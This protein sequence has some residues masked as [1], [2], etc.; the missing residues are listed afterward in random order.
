MN[1]T[2]I[3][4]FAIW[5]RNKLMDDMAYKAGLLG[6]SAD[7][8]AEPLPQSTAAMQ[9]IDIGTDTPYRV[10]GAAVRQ[11]QKF[12]DYIHQKEAD[13]DYAA[14]YQ[15][16]I[17]ETAYT[18]FN[19][20][21][22]VRFMEVNGYL[23]S[24]VRVLSSEQAG[25]AEPDMVTT[26]F[27]TDLEFTAEETQDI[28]R[29]KREN[30]INTL[31]RRLFIRQCNALNDILPHL[32]EKT[33]DYTELLLNISVTDHD[34][35]V[36]HLVHDIDEADFDI[37]RGGQVEIIG[38]LYQYYN[39]EPK[40]ETFAL[41]KKNIKVTK[42]RIPSA[43]QLFTPDWIVRYMVENSLGRLWTEGRTASNFDWKYYIPEAQQEPAVQE[44]LSHIRAEYKKLRPEDLTIIDP[45]MGSGHILI[46]AF[47][48]LMQIYT[49]QGYSE[50]DAAE[51]ILTHN[52]Y[53]LDIDERAFQ[54]A[55]FSVLMK[56][57][58]YDR[59]IL[60]KHVDIHLCAIPESNGLA[61][62]S[63]ISGKDVLGMEQLDLDNQY[64]EMADYL[65]D[66]FHDAKEYG[67]ILQVKE[68]DYDGL[69][70]YIDRMQ[71][72]G[73]NLIRSAWIREIA[74]RMPK[75]VQQAKIM[76]RQYWTCVTNPP[77]M[78]SSNMNSKLT[79]YVKKQYP[80]SKS[81][82]STVCMEM[83]LHMLR[84][85]GIM[86][87]I[88]IPVWMFL[89]SYE[90]LRNE[91]QQNDTYINMVHLGR[92]VFGSDFGTT[93][94]VIAKQRI[95][96]YSGTYRRL[97]MK[98]GAVDSVEQKEKWFLEGV[99]SYTAS[100]E[101]FSKIPGEP[102]AYWASEKFID[103]FKYVPLKKETMFKEGLT[104]ANNDLFLRYW[105]E[106]S[107]S[108][109]SIF[110]NT[111]KWI[112]YNKGGSFRKWYGNRLY[113]IDWTNE[114][115]KI[116]D[117]PGSSF[118]NSVYQRKEGG[119][120][121]A[122]TSGAFSVRYSEKGF[123]FDSKGTMFF[124]KEL[125]G[126]VICYLNSN[127][128]NKLLTFV[129]PTL[130]YRFGTIEKL[131][132]LKVDC[133]ASTFISL[134]R[135]DWDSFETSWDFPSHPLAVMAEEKR[136]LLPRD[137]RDTQTPAQQDRASR[138]A[139]RY[140]QWKKE[141]NHRFDTLQS[142][143]TELNR[144]FIDIYGLQDELTP[145]VADKDI[146]VHRLYDTKDDVPESM[147]GSN[148]ILTKQD[149]IKSLISYAVGCLFGR[150]S[151]DMP[152]LA[153]AGGDWDSSHYSTFLP[154]RDN[155]IPIAD[156]EYMKDDMTGLFCAWVKAVYGADTLEENLDFIAHA[157][158]ARGTT[159]RDVIRN[160]FL[161]DFYKDHVKT[162]KKRPIYW[163]FDSGRQ[164]GFK[165]LIYMHRYD[166]DTIGRVRVEYLHKME[167]IY[168]SE[169]SRMQDIVDNGVNR[170]EAAKATKNKEKLQKQLKECRD[171]DENIAHLAVDR[172][173]IDLD[174]GVKIN[175]E[176]I[177]TD[178]DG[179]KY[180]ILAKI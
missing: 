112:P 23:P 101:N 9:F 124:N 30:H 179:K 79:A 97:F 7:G 160:Y 115:K 120:F 51:S 5:A 162:Y 63:D 111:Y 161:R 104:T 78:G 56:A 34:G 110:N 168:E 176:K 47:D 169:C 8:I 44:Q 85:N 75:L 49:S 127:V 98:Q 83:T 35:I 80:D 131:P 59:R 166:A 151:L 72:E 130:D 4:N 37:T 122:L 57:R 108:K 154:D 134:S 84:P 22:A 68:Q 150:Y 60:T 175:Y 28:L 11:R 53:G 137:T 116:K 67:S 81:D 91:I 106:V 94:F 38:W 31:F 147:K 71:R 177:Q 2:A 121:S 171:Y 26:P 107:K 152:G 164:N 82:M 129:C 105:Y 21:I 18:W 128:L 89:S 43:T 180:P 117:Y 135:Q 142:N 58:Q 156:T 87:M 178:R 16:V 27:D 88:N 140:D 149:V 32:F 138:I 66:T 165:A 29:L 132:F 157:L 92:G 125:L 139:A 54:L 1:K 174:D 113:V 74:A 109:I 170:R 76:N 70:D 65:I 40:E 69:L 14:A 86:A 36:W 52:L 100:Q 46:Y 62:W 77:Y 39:T 123:A 155:V 148:Y 10:E 25:K 119:T 19:R 17:E 24:G 159:S 146:T 172:I 6:V 93:S 48:V 118:R 3:K 33:A 144:I 50:R 41:L 158:G 42:E 173:A 15:S 133:D 99:G 163:L 61:K 20:L 45:C 136:N 95:V 64:V 145:E 103:L 12:V 114:G 167:R 143:E 102:I 126:A 141:V 13:T 73:G 153:Y 55:Y 96:N 90:K